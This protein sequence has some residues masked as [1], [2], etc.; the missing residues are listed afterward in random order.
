MVSSIPR[1]MVRLRIDVRRHVIFGS[2]VHL[3]RRTHS[4]LILPGRYVS[5]W[6][7][8]R[9]A[10]LRSRYTCQAGSGL[11]PAGRHISTA[12]QETN[13]C[14]MRAPDM[15]TPHPTLLL[16]SLVTTSIPQASIRRV[17]RAT[18]GSTNQQLL[19]MDPVP[20]GWTLP[21]RLWDA[22]ARNKTKARE[23]R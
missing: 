9:P 3:N 13:E 23:D 4:I 10:E 19:M 6:V 12:R 5:S 16:A 1:W 7:E 22:R 2:Q 15:K 14:W 8:N 20:D 17:H 21:E 11:N 18:T